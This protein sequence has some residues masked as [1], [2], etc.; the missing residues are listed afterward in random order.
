MRFEEVD[1]DRMT[2]RNKVVYKGLWDRNIPGIEIKPTSKSNKKNAKTTY[3]II[4]EKEQAAEII[5]KVFCLED[6][7]IFDS[8]YK[9]AVSGNGDEGEKILTLHSSSRLA[10]LAFYN[11]EKHPITLTLVDADGNPIKVEF[12]YSVF[13][14]K[15]PVIGYP[16]NMDVVLLSKDRKKVLFLESKFAEYYIGAT[17]KSA[18]ISNAYRENKYSKE[19]YDR[20]WLDTIG[21]GIEEAADESKGFRL[22]MKDKSVNYLDGFKQMISHYIGI[23]NRMDGKTIAA[24]KKSEEANNILSIVTSMDATVYLGEILFDGFKL[25]EGF[26]EELDP[27]VALKCYSK[28]YH[29]LSE[30]MNQMN[31]TGKEKLSAGR[32]IVL[33]EDLRYSDIFKSDA[34]AKLVRD[35]YTV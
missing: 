6:T 34:V 24:D 23:R 16:S 8:K 20:E 33:P 10:L 35:F 32:F 1:F 4:G 14:F 22:F 12:D 18:V 9:M 5:K 17:E 30:R 15:N 7:E 25:P 26:K 21:I 13:E 11:I 27:N 31:N 29:S 3:K 2:D 19:L 28:I